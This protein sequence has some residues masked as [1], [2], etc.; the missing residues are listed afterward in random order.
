MIR[1]S[2]SAAGSATTTVLFRNQ[3]AR[4]SSL[5]KKGDFTYMESGNTIEIIQGSDIAEYAFL[6]LK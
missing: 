1:L 2:D 3:V 4:S 6:E 5:H